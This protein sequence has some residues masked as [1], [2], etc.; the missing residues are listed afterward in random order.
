MTVRVVQPVASHEL[1]AR[2]FMVRAH[3][4][5]WLT[6]TQTGHV[7]V[8]DRALAVGTELD[9]G[10][11]LEGLALAPGGLVLATGAHLRLV[12]PDGRERWRREGRFGACHVDGQGQLW[13]VRHV[14]DRRL[15]L[16]VRDL[17]DGQP[18]RSA[19][20]EDRYFRSTLWLTEAPDDQVMLWMAAGQDGQSNFVLALQDAGLGARRLPSP[21]SD[22]ESVPVAFAPDG[23][24]AVLG[25][26]AGLFWLDWP[27]WQVRAHLPWSE[28]FGVEAVE[29]AAQFGGEVQ[30]LPGGFAVASSADARLHL[31]DLKRGCRV[32]ELLL[33]GHP[34]VPTSTLYPRLAD[35]HAPTTDFEG[36]TRGPAGLVLTVH[37]HTRLEVSRLADWSPD[38][39]R[40]W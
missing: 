28:V 1:A 16:A 22:D 5:G 39:G 36:G 10:G 11:P 34:I 3:A 6:A 32:G 2:A 9:A 7:T 27:A 8:L 23:P 35:D 15:E 13:T 31:V 25:G 24:R 17:A 29:L 33:S 4:S 38:P 26:S 30:A 40:A 37:G 20:L 21:V 14:D 12:A 19:E 18:R